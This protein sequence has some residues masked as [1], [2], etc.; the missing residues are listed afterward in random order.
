MSTAVMAMAAE[1]AAAE[2][3]ESDASRR[4]GPSAAAEGD[5]STP[6]VLPG[7]IYF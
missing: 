1:A 3:G 7:C 2:N 4:I 6:V 5:F